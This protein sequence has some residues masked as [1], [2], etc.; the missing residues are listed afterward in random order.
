LR[1]LRLEALR[2]RPDAFGSTLE[3]ESGVDGDTWRG[4]TTGDGWGGAVATFVANDAGTL[5]GMATGF[6]PDDDPRSVW[7]FAM[8]VRPDRRSGGIG[9]ELVASVARWAVDRPGVD[10]ILLR[11]TTSND[12][13][14]RF[15]AGCGF[16]GTSDPPEPL[17]EGSALRTQRMRLLVGEFTS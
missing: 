10:Q 3:R 14:V 12:A 15:Y 11:V 7:L 9:R 17:R 1:S 16:V 5:V 13:A 2:D 8:W 4:W 6:N